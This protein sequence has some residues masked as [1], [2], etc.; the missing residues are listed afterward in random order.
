MVPLA[1][2]IGSFATIQVVSAMGKG[3]TPRGVPPF[4]QTLGEESTLRTR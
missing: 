4:R 2:E 1:P 3:G